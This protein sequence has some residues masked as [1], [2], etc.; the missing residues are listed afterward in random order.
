MNACSVAWCRPS[1]R[2]ASSRVSPRSRQRG[3]EVAPEPAG[4]EALLA[5]ML[6][7]ADDEGRMHRFG[8]AAPVGAPLRGIGDAIGDE[9]MFAAGRKD[10]G[11]GA[12]VVEQRQLERARPRPQLADGQRRDRL[13]RRDEAVQAL[14][15]EPARAVTDE[16]QRHRIHAGQAGELVGGHRRQPSIERGRQVVT[17]VARRSRDGVEVVE[18]PLS[19]R[20]GAF[21]AAHVIGQVHVDV[22]QRQ[23]VPVEPLQVGTVAHPALR[24]HR[25]QRRETARVLLEGLDAQQFETAVHR[26]MHARDLTD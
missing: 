12:Q 19:G 13:E 17:D 18:Q 21:P 24:G 14:R 11:P 6:Q 5:G 22:P 7:Q 4:R 10:I 1:E 26:R 2:I 9:A 16:L 15:V 20:R 8:P 3:V 25:Q 23:H